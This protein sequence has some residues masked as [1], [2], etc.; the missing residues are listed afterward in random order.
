VSKKKMVEV[1]PMTFEE[2]WADLLKPLPWW[3]EVGY[4]VRRW[5]RDLPWWFRWRLQRRHQYHIVR[6]GLKPGYY[7]PY[8]RVLYAV[9]EETRRFVA[10]EAGPRG[11]IDWTADEHSRAEWAA[12]TAAAEWWGEHRDTMFD[13]IDP[14]EEMRVWDEGVERMVAVLRHLRGMWHA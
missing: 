7:D 2:F 3:Q 5:C 9:L 14:D 1:K 12:Y 11:Y 6:L 13:I 10:H 8:L 4:R